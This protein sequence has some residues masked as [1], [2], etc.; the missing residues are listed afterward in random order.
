MVLTRDFFLRARDC[1]YVNCIISIGLVRY[2]WWFWI[3][4]YCIVCVCVCIDLI[5]QNPFRF[6][7]LNLQVHA[8]HSLNSNFSVLWITYLSQLS[9][10]NLVVF[11]RLLTRNENINVGMCTLVEQKIVGGY[12]LSYCS[13]FHCTKHLYRNDSL[14]S[15]NNRREGWNWK[16]KSIV[17]LEHNLT[18]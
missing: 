12:W 3:L 15:T 14:M 13:V 8:F 7:V 2:C 5:S 17:W 16:Y 6:H 10:K 9:M 18:K 1:L 4:K 11:H